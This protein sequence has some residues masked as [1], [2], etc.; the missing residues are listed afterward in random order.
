LWLAPLLRRMR[1]CF[2]SWRMPFCFHVTVERG[3]SSWTRL[4][5]AS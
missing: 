1:S 4:P 3:C 2:W 5:S